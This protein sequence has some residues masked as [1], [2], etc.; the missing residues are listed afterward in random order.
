MVMGQDQIK[1][2][3]HWH[4]SLGSGEDNPM[5]DYV[6]TDG[7]GSIKAFLDLTENM[8]HKE[9]AGIDRS[10][11]EEVLFEALGQGGRQGAIMRLYAYVVTWVPCTGCN[12]FSLN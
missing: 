1:K 11:L 10:K 9:F 2:V 6:I 8:F 4:V 5:I 7:P 3:K 12:N